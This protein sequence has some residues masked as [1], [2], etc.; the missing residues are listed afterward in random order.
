[1][2]RYLFVVSQE[3]PEL[4]DYLTGWFAGIPDVDVI[5]DRRRAQHGEQDVSREPE[6][7]QRP[8]VDEEIRKTG[9]AIVS[10]EA[11]SEP[12]RAEG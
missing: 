12:S 5:L 9:F 1:M 3:Q 8:G 6:R 2:G 7:R 4:R 10:S 11:P